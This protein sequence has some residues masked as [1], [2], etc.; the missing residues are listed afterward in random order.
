[1]TRSRQLTVSVVLISAL[2]PQ[3][4]GRAN[5]RVKKQSDE[6]FG[7]DV[8]LSES[9]LFGKY[10]NASGA[11]IKDVRASIRQAGKEVASGIT[12]AQGNFRV[13]G[14]QTGVYE[15]IIGCRSEFIRVWDSETAPPMAN[16]S[17]RIVRDGHLQGNGGTGGMLKI[18]GPGGN[19][20]DLFGSLF[21]NSTS[22]KDPAVTIPNTP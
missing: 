18:M 8:M 12:D 9:T 3:L 17:A 20:L 19:A 7:R 11:G 6:A 21:G 13:S 1:M 2:L 10:V 15:V 4:T 22:M 5:D 14:L 16:P